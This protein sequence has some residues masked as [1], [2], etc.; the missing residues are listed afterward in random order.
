M[1]GIASAIV[2]M[3][4]KAI[5]HGDIKLD[6]VIITPAPHRPL[7]CDFGMSVRRILDS[8]R[9]S[10]KGG[11]SGAHVSPEVHHHIPKTVGS[12]TW[13]FGILIIHVRVHVTLLH[14]RC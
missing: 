9:D 12:D 4:E 3:H 11:G 1:E 8:T 10:V 6:N 13:A 7:L 5:I 2:H 14:L